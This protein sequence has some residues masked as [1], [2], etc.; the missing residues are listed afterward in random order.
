[1][2]SFTASIIATRFSIGVL[3]WTLWIELKTKPRPRENLAALQHP[4]APL[5]WGAERQRSLRVDTAAPEVVWLPRIMK[6]LRA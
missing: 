4:C 5:R 2:N 1:L 6:W 3:A